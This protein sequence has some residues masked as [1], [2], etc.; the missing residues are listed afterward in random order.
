MYYNSVWGTVCDNGWDF[1]DAQVVCRQLDYGPP[2]AAR[3]KAY[4]GQGSG[5]IWLDNLNCNGNEL[6]I[7]ECPHAG[8]GMH[9]CE[10]NKDAGVKC[11]YGNSIVYFCT[12]YLSYEVVQFTCTTC[13]SSCKCMDPHGMKV[14]WSCITMVNLVQF[15]MM[16]G[17]LMMQKLFVIN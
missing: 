16:N 9:D 6:T 15:V 5:Q 14:E 10:H 3:S 12:N 4:Y 2:I 11:S 13:I 17:I 8:W 1:N 7:G